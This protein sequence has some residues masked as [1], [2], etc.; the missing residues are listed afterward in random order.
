MVEPGDLEAGDVL[1]GP[2]ATN[3]GVTLLAWT[4]DSGGDPGGRRLVWVV[5]RSAPPSSVVR[6]SLW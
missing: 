4:P 6:R 3:L 5:Q 1:F 2:Y